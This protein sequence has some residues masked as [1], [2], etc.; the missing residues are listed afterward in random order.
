MFTT[1]LHFSIPHLF[2]YCYCLSFAT[3]CVD[4]I[5]LQQ[6]IGFQVAPVTRQVGKSTALWPLPVALAQQL[7]SWPCCKLLVQVL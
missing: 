4:Q 1:I 2:I 7:N 5:R 3:F 6:G